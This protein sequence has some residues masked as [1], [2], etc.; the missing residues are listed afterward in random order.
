[1]IRLPKPLE[2]YSRRRILVSACCIGL[3]ALALIGW[4]LFD[5]GWLPVMV[6]MSV[7]QGLGTVAL[8]LFL[9]VVAIDLRRLGAPTEQPP[10]MDRMSSGR[11]RR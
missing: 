11:P 6:A 10:K 1:M 9:F 3:A 7:G 5:Q 8:G 2:D 4:S